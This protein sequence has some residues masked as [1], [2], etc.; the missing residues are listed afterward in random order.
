MVTQLFTHFVR[1]KNVPL[2]TGLYFVNLQAID[3]LHA[4]AAA[5]NNVAYLHSQYVAAPQ[6]PIDAD[7]SRDIIITIPPLKTSQEGMYLRFCE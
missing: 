2:F 3:D 5:R 7:Q 1:Y 4:L 6:S